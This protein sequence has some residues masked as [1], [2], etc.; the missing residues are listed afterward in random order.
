VLA[1]HQVRQLCRPSARN[2]QRPV[3]L[4]RLRLANRAVSFVFNGVLIMC[5]QKIDGV[6][7]SSMANVVVFI[8]ASVWLLAT[9]T[10]FIVSIAMMLCSYYRLTPMPVESFRG[11]LTLLMPTFNRDIEVVKSI[12]DAYRA[13]SIV[14]EVILIEFDGGHHLG[15]PNTVTMPNDLRNRFAPYRFPLITGPEVCPNVTTEAIM[16]VDDDCLLSEALLCSLYERL[17]LRPNALH[18]IE[19]RSI[20][21]S[22]DYVSTHRPRIRAGGVRVGML[23]TWCAM[24]TTKRMR[25][26]ETTF[27]NRYWSFAK[28]LNGEDIA[29]SRLFGECY[30]HEFGWVCWCGLPMF[31]TEVRFLTSDFALSRKPY[32]VQERKEIAL[33]FHEVNL[34]KV[35]PTTRPQNKHEA[36]V[37]FGSR[38]EYIVAILFAYL[39]FS[40]ACARIV[41]IYRKSPGSE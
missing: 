32:F 29:V 26:V 12:V 8:A 27:R 33:R 6:Y 16:T 3:D 7:Q 40:V 13:M 37:Y 25:Q 24:A 14:D 35:R 41:W 22:G 1:V 20:L 31:N 23:L 39:L 34:M 19:G 15:L 11:Y 38:R 21:P 9:F 2:K 4:R 36:M 17:V 5:A 10:V 28:P 30:M 18:G